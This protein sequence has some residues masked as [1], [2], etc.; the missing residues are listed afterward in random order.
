MSEI[1]S[2]MHLE[3][4]YLKSRMHVV[5]NKEMMTSEGRYGPAHFERILQR[6]Q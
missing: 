4:Q 1:N 6:G 5:R 2:N 3:H